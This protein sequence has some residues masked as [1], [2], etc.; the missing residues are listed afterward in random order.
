MLCPLPSMLTKTANLLPSNFPSI[1]MYWFLVVLNLWRPKICAFSTNMASSLICSRENKSIAI[2]MAEVGC[3]L[4]FSYHMN[5]RWCYCSCHQYWFSCPLRL[6]WVM[7]AAAQQVY[8][9]FSL[10]EL[11]VVTANKIKEID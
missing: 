3:Y 6:T 9:I 1:W 4:L 11:K 5:T 7:V 10:N 8:L 2:L